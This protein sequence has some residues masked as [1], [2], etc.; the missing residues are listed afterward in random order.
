MEPRKL[1]RRAFLGTL[2]G[3]VV[4]VGIL[5]R[6]GIFQRS[7]PGEEMLTVYTFGDSILDCSRYNRYGVHPG[8]LIVRNDDRLFPEFRGQDLS[9]RGPARLDHRA[10]DGATVDSPPRQVR[11]M[12]VEGRSVALLTVGGNEVPSRPSSD[13]GGGIDRHGQ[14][15]V[16]FPPALRIRAVPACSVYDP[17]WSDHAWS[18]RPSDAANGRGT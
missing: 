5:Q 10:Q 11:G 3:G 7:E 16:A 6:L 8:Q 4:A 15:R 13:S 2:A 9:S 17:T 18:F 1:S 14:A 12:K